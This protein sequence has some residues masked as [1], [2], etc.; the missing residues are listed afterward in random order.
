M[1]DG[2]PTEARQRHRRLTEELDEAN[3]RYYVLDQPTLTDADYDRRM[4]E[5]RALEERHPELVTPDSPTQRVGAPIVTD[6]ATVQHLE[7]MQ[8]LDNAMSADELLA[9]DE[10]VVK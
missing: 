8:S 6:F 1:S 3:Y 9:W 4:R 5:I 7:R 2:V 10:R